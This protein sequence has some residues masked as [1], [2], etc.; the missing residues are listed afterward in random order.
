MSSPAL[1]S[2]AAVC[3]L[4]DPAAIAQRLAELPVDHVAV[5]GQYVGAL[6]VALFQGSHLAQDAA[7]VTRTAW[8][9]GTAATAIGQ[10]AIAAMA[11]GRSAG[12]SK[13]RS[14]E[15]LNRA[16]AALGSDPVAGE[17]PIDV[18]GVLPAPGGAGAGLPQFGRREE[19]AALAGRQSASGALSTRR[20]ATRVPSGK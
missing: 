9:T 14:V 19:A 2:A 15:E 17:G 7:A 4:P 3:G 12:R 1:S 6:A 10:A 16:L 5:C 11:A 13:M 8:S 20:T 18:R